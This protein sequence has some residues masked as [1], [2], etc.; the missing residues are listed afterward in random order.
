MS[1]IWLC[2]HR[3]EDQGQVVTYHISCPTQGTIEELVRQ[4]K[5]HGLTSTARL[6]DHA[7]FSSMRTIFPKSVPPGQWYE[8]WDWMDQWEIQE[9]IRRLVLID[10]DTAPEPFTSG[11]DIRRWYRFP[12]ALVLCCNN[13]TLDELQGHVCECLVRTDSGQ[14]GWAKPTE[15]GKELITIR[16]LKRLRDQTPERT[17]SALLASVL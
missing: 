15:I 5:K 16:V 12:C 7:S 3:F 6:V 4:S 8:C 10:R 11:P 9:S 13:L 2:Y 14:P 1:G 17:L